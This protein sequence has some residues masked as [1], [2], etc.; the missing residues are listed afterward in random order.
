VTAAQ[1]SAEALP[2]LKALH[3]K[4]VVV[5]YG[6]NA[7]TDDVLKAAFAADMFPAQLR[8]PSRRRARWRPTGQAISEAGI[9]GIQG[10]LP[11]DHTEVLDVA[12]W[13]CSVRWQGTRR[14]INATPYAVGITGETRTCS[15]RSGVASTSTALRPTSASC[16]D[17]ERV[18][19]A[20]VLDLIAAAVFRCRPSRQMSTA[21]AHINADTAAADWPKRGRE[22][23][24]ML[25]DVEGLYTSWPDPVRWS[26]RSSCHPH[27]TAADLESGMCQDRPVLRAP[28][29]RRRAER[30]CHRRPRRTCVL[31]SCSR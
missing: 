25:T 24:L 20:A 21:C 8:D 17:V 12:G 2:W 9:A 23:L 13:C 19:T 5:K 27:R 7:M 31:S 3:G 18:N 15:P 1:V 10:W 11:G 6:G 4:I 16:G 26:A 30:T 14:L 29:S 28:G 22:K